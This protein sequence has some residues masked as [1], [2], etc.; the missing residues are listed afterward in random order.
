MLE[1]WS[2][3]VTAGSCMGAP[4]KTRKAVWVAGAWQH[5]L[6][7]LERVKRERKDYERIAKCKVV[8]KEGRRRHEVIA[9]MYQNS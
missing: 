1:R 4:E 9:D 5:A 7:E 2:S 3:V 6:S 8:Q